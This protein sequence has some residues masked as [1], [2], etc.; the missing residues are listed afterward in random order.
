MIPKFEPP[1]VP[2]MTPEFTGPWTPEVHAE[3]RALTRD[4]SPWRECSARNGGCHCGLVW[5]LKADGVAVKVDHE[6]VADDHVPRIARLTAATHNAVPMLLDEI[7]RL[8]TEATRLRGV[9]SSLPRRC[10]TC[11]AS[12]CWDG[13]V[14]HCA[15]GGPLG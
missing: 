10:R 13:A 8:R 14:T 2:D 4:E 6:F 5:D 15:C 9:V 12:G 1:A 11:G 3:L 7:E